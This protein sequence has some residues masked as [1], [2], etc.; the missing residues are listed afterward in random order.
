MQQLTLFTTTTD[1][2]WDDHTQTWESGAHIGN[3][4]QCR[5]D[6]DILTWGDK[7]IKVT[8]HMK[9]KYLSPRVVVD[10]L[11][12][13]WRF[14]ELINNLLVDDEGFKAE[15]IAKAIKQSHQSTKMALEVGVDVGIF[16]KRKG[17]IYAANKSC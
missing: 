15:S 11:Q 8:S 6:G 9:T 3:C 10:Y 5:Y 16:E 1:T 17:G 4:Q 2:P 14:I 13:S 12:D 7:S